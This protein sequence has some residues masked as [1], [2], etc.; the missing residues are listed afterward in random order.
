M[1]KFKL[2]FFYSFM[3]VSG[4]LIIYYIGQFHQ[5]TLSTFLLNNFVVRNFIVENLL[6]LSQIKQFF[7]KLINNKRQ[8]G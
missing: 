1:F 6:G 4:S 5:I 7:L 3:P 8:C 2:F